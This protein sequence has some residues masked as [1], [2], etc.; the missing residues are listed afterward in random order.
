MPHVFSLQE[1]FTFTVAA[2]GSDISVFRDS[3]SN[4][5]YVIKES[6]NWIISLVP[7]RIL[8]DFRKATINSL[9]ALGG[10]RL[11]Y[12]MSLVPLSFSEAVTLFSSTLGRSELIAL[13]PLSPFPDFVVLSNMVSV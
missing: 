8:N 11:S 6:S 12:F 5:S 7:V 4:I 10:Y 2:S 13:D 9:H 1:Y 3:C